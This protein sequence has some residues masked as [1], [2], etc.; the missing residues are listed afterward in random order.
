MRK[1]I[2]DRC[3]AEMTEDDER[4]IVSDERTNSHG[5]SR[6]PSL[7][8]CPSCNEKLLMVLAGVNLEKRDG[9]K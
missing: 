1:I 4:F 6:M 9:E 2:C 3:K 8:L 5:Y 7:D